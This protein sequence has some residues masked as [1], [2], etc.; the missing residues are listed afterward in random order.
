MQ[1][2]SNLLIRVSDIKSFQAW[3]NIGMGLPP[4]SDFEKSWKKKNQKERYLKT[5][6]MY[7]KIILVLPGP[8]TASDI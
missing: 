7:V 3:E 2:E 1:E 6:W 5:R 4:V 8:R